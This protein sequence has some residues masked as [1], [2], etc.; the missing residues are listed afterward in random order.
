MTQ[1]DKEFTGS[2][3]ALY[4]RYLG[5]VLFAPYADD[6]AARVKAHKLFK[7]ETSP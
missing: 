7:K 1:P 5:P 2:I 4:D 6:L 3:P